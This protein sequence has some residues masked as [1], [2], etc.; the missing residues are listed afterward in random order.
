MTL[1]NAEDVF[2]WITDGQTSWCRHRETSN[3]RN[4]EFEVADRKQVAVPGHF[5]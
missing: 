3:R 4:G 2:E 1:W 5:A